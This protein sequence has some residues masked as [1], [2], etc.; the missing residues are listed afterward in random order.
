[1]SV[2]TTAHKK[3]TLPGDSPVVPPLATLV[4]VF[5]LFSL[6]IPH[7]RTMQVISGIIGTASIN[8]VVVAGVTLLMISGEFD[9]S[10]G[11]IV[12]MGGF[13]FGRHVLGGGSPII[14]LGMALLVTAIMGFLNGLLTVRTGVPSFIAT[15]GT[16]S[17]YRGIVWVYSG[18]VLL[19]GTKAFPLDDLFNG[20]LEFINN[21]FTRASFGVPTLWAIAV[22][23]V[24]Q[25]LLTRTRFGNQVFATGGNPEAAL[26]QGVNVKRVK[27]LCFTL[28]GALCGIAGALTYGQFLS[29]FVAT[30]RGL[31]LTAIAAA[32]VGGTVLTGGTGSIVG[33]LL[34]ILLINTLRSGAVLAGLPSD[35]FEAI[36]G[37]TIIAASVLNQRMRGRL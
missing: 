8:A 26:A 27:V 1:M 30:G 2:T 4:A 19:Q 13:I 29:I 22:C 25:F 24:F 7:F 34:G 6:F 10:V 33:G 17:I 3:R 5:V 31:E 14:G 28:N 32:V 18:G 9:L 21:L 20:R 35:N 12:A 16:R 11:S 15:L 37:V 36:V 23:L